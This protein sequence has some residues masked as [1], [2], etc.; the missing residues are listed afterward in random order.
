MILTS[1]ILTAAALYLLTYGGRTSIEETVVARDAMTEHYVT[2]YYKIE[3][4]SDDRGVPK[5]EAPDSEH[6]P[7]LSL[8]NAYETVFTGAPEWQQNEVAWG[9]ISP[10]TG[11]QDTPVADQVQHLNNWVQEA[12]G[13]ND[14]QDRS[15]QAYQWAHKFNAEHDEKVDI[16]FGH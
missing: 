6:A 1:I 7:S 14:E 13:R 8:N 9:I 4:V 3:S 11:H 16:D 12:E 2:P 10:I 5:P 15:W